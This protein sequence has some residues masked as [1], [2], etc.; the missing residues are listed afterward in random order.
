VIPHGFP[1]LNTQISSAH[2]NVILRSRSN[3]R[4]YSRQTHCRSCSTCLPSKYRYVNVCVKLIVF[5]FILIAHICMDRPETAG[6]VSKPF[7]SSMDFLCPLRCNEMHIFEHFNRATGT[8]EVVKEQFQHT[9]VINITQFKKAGMYRCRCS[10][11]SRTDKCYLQLNIIPDKV[12]ANFSQA[13]LNRDYNAF[14]SSKGNP[15]P[16]MEVEFSSSN[17]NYTTT[18]FYDNETFTRYLIINIPTFTIHCQNIT[19]TCSACHERTTTAL[20]A[21]SETDK[22][23]GT[24]PPTASPPVSTD[25]L[26]GRGTS[27]MHSV[28][29]MTLICIGL[30]TVKT[31]MWL[32]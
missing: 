23:E 8:Y 17:C 21:T 11:H 26:G 30:V 12:E 25:P 1:L 4:G 2:P 16:T 19:V 14:C 24:E 6:T 15:P 18:L 22:E 7:N 5:K 3:D 13:I 10:D 9:A 20:N 32:M 29:S 27:T 28:S 31:W